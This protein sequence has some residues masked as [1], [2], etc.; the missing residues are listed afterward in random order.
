M[1]RPCYFPKI[2]LALVLSGAALGAGAEDVK[3]EWQASGVYNKLNYYY[4]MRLTLSADKP[5]GIKA[6]PADLSVPL[7]GKLQIGL[8]EAPATYFVI[9]DEPE[10]KPSRLFVD[11][12]ANG[13]LTD[14]PPATWKGRNG[15]ATDGTILTNYSGGADLQLAYGSEKLT[16]HLCF[17]RFDVHDPSRANYVNNLFYYRDYGR[18]GEVSLAGK[19]YKAML[20]DDSASGDFRPPRSAAKSMVKLFLDLNGDGKFEMSGESFDASQPFKVGEAVYEVSGLDAAGGTFQIAKSSKPVPEEAKS[21]PRVPRVHLAAGSKA[22]PFEAKTTDGLAIHFPES[23][24]GKLVLLD[25]WATWCPP[26]R[27]EVPHMAEVY[28]KFHGKGLEVLGIS[29]DQANA[30]E[31]LAK[32]TK[33]NHMPWPEVYDGEYWKSAVAQTYSINSI[34]HPFLVDGDTGMIVADGVKLRGE[35]L[36]ATIEQALAKRH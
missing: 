4:P 7:Y 5:E 29:L 23:Y 20:V 24:K 36:A 9:V 14:D 8:A 13:D 3:L 21:E 34:P 18:V 6:V 12:N 28:E 19:T 17:Y 15:K 35:Q 32:F 22:L 10:G 33:E 31:L 25:F 1:L 27:A 30:S 11:A 2:W 16:L 26:C